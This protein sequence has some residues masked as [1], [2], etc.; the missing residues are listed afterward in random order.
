M[1]AGYFNPLKNKCGNFTRCDPIRFR[2]D[3]MTK[4]ISR[5]IKET[6]ILLFQHDPFSA[7]I[8]FKRQNLTSIDISR[9][10]LLKSKVDPCIESL[11]NLQW[12][13]TQNI[14]IKNHISDD[15]KYQITL[16]SPWFIYKYFSGLRVK[17]PEV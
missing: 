13:W 12:P 16:S 17:G 1:K 4:W 3:G 8:N 9:R 10:Q 2:T 7:R 15:L 11:I 6:G 5:S 14:C